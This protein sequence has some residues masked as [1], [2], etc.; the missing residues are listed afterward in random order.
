VHQVT[1]GNPAVVANVHIAPT[2][3]SHYWMLHGLGKDRYEETVAR[4]KRAVE[5]GR[6]SEN[7]IEYL[8]RPPPDPYD[9]IVRV[10]GKAESWLSWWGP[11]TIASVKDHM[12]EARVPL[13]LMSGTDDNYNDVARFDALEAAA[14]N[15]PS[16]TQIWYQNCNHSLEGF[17][18]RSAR[19]IADWLSRYHLLATGS[20][21]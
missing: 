7:V 20:E 18:Q 15:A 16:V 4:A 19:D 14:V 2:A 11:E 6:S 10:F 9:G 5:E 21:S 12:D 13:L 1:F 3:D 17:E 8:R